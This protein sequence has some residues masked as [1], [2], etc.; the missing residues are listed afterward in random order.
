MITQKLYGIKDLES[1][2]S[3]IN[4]I[5]KDPLYK[6]SSSVLLR[7]YSSK[8]SYEKCLHLKK[9]LNEK[10]PKAV[11]LGLALNNRDELFKN[12]CVI[13]KAQF[14]EKTAV[15]ILEYSCDSKEFC[16]VASQANTDLDALPDIKAVEVLSSSP[17]HGFY[18]FISYISEQRDDI[19]FF[20]V[21][22]GFVNTENSENFEEFY[23]SI[24]NQQKE[25]KQIDDVD[26]PLDS[27]IEERL[28]K[29]F[30][31]SR[32]TRQKNLTSTPNVHPDHFVMGTNNLYLNGIVMAVYS[33]TVL[34]VHPEYFMGWHKVGKELTAKGVSENDRVAKFDDMSAASIYEKYLNVKMDEK[35]IRNI[36][37]FPLVTERNGFEIARIPPVYDDKGQLYFAADVREGEKYQISY[38]NP[39]DILNQ[40]KE[41]AQK[42]HEFM[43]EILCLYVCANHILFLKDLHAKEIEPF[44]AFA[45]DA[46]GVLGNSEIYRYNRQG[47]VL[48]SMLIAIGLRED[49]LDDNSCP[50]FLTPDN[51]TKESKYKTIPLYQRLASFL[52]RTTEEL[53]DALNASKNASEA[54]SQFLSNM[55]HEIRTPINTILGMN[56]LIL[57][58]TNDHKIVEYAHNI[59]QAGS[60]LLNLINDILDFSKI[61]S[62][63]LE[64]IENDYSLESILSEIYSLLAYR[65]KDKNL[66]FIFE[67]DERIPG[68]L[69]GD[70]VRIKQILINILTNAI[71]YTKEGSIV[72]RL[73][74]VSASEENTVIS[75]EVED[76]G[77]GIKEE[78]I[79]KLTLAFE[80]IEENKNRTI[81]GTGLGMSITVKLLK[82]MNSS[83]NV[84]SV[85][86]KGSRFTFNLKQRIIN[87]KPIGSFDAEKHFTHK[88]SYHQLFTAPDTRVLLV[89]DTAM[90]LTVI[91]GLLRETRIQI[92]TAQSGY[93]GYEMFLENNY[94]LIMLDHR[95]PGMDGIQTFEKIKATD[96]FRNSP[97]PVI[98]LTANAVTGARD[99]YIEKGFT[100]YLSKP[101]DPKILE[102]TI[103][104]LLPQNLVTYEKADKHLT[105]DISPDNKLPQ[106]LYGIKELDTDKGLFNCGSS[107]NYLSAIK[108]FHDSII[109]GCDE[110]STYLK[111]KDYK[112][113]TTKVHALKSSSKLIGATE[114]SSKAKRLEDAGNSGYYEEIHSQ[115]PALYALYRSYESLLSPISN[116]QKKNDE[117]TLYPIETS[118]LKEAY[119]A[120]IN[121][122]HDY[123]IDSLNMILDTLKDYLLEDKDKRII[124]NLAGAVN[125]INWPKLQTIAEEI[126]NG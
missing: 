105:E 5:L 111:D 54:K 124:E 1:A 15:H 75:F 87:K 28:T 81:E 8:I 13:V 60:N 32:K 51:E 110:L 121:A 67:I 53:S 17:A 85:Y 108:I 49:E 64:L 88:H 52:Q 35:M 92:D 107:D 19:Y 10:L 58:E 46:F 62:G 21:E 72:T 82:M 66:K 63:K 39:T 34:K 61:E 20:G 50:V 126:S 120:I 25:N 9:Y 70:E 22:A 68:T 47:G 29:A 122:V 27:E 74:L 94:H 56:E 18:N 16:E 48:N 96:K 71:K 93:E 69:Y 41:H 3:I 104:R 73:K 113:F 11:L 80:R 98:A 89:D 103:S 24:N 40:A 26:Y 65:A 91:V 90:N 57:R 44:K 84:F 101:V 83:L 43:P 45:P 42:M 79:P 37:E 6:N 12:N 117:S 95:M 99:M 36:C 76:T 112:N 7:C 109:S 125:D 100:D 106:W 4:T 97:I 119:D 2:D 59:Q 23:K 78:D 118:E 31:E 115:F 30:E 55:S 86:G 77:I 123:D 102:K 14:F 33:S 116:N 38:A 114:L